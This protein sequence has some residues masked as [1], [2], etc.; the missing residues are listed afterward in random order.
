MLFICFKDGNK[1]KKYKLRVF[2][3]VVILIIISL[4]NPNNNSIK[5]VFNM[6]GSVKKLRL[7]GYI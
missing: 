7:R 2:I 1:A 3:K 6:H 4:L 5:Q